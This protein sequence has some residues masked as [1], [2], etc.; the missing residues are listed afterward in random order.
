[1][2]SAYPFT[3]GA[4]D[5]AWMKQ[6]ETGTGNVIV[7]ASGVVIDRKVI[8]T[9]A[10]NIVGNRHAIHFVGSGQILIVMAD[11]RS[12]FTVDGAAI[13]WYRD[14]N[15]SPGSLDCFLALNGNFSFKNNTVASHVVAD[16]PTD[17]LW[18]DKG[19]KNWFMRLGS[20]TTNVTSLVVQNNTFTNENQ[21]AAGLLMMSG[22]TYVGNIRIEDNS[23]SNFHGAIYVSHALGASIDDN[24]LF[25]NSLGNIVVTDA[26]TSQIS[27]NMIELPGNGTTGDGMT[28]G[29][30]DQDVVRNN[31][32]ING[33]CYGIWVMQGSSRTTF[34]RNTIH[35]GITDAV[36]IAGSGVFSDIRIIENTLTDQHGNAV[37][38]T[39]V[40][41]LT[42]VDNVIGGNHSWATGR[43]HLFVNVTGLS[44][45][46]NVWI[47]TNVSTADAGAT[48]GTNLYQYSFGD[49]PVAQ[50]SASST[51]AEA[52]ATR[53]ALPTTSAA[54][55]KAWVDSL[56]SGTGSIT[57]PT[58]GVTIDRVVVLN[59]P[60]QIIGNGATLRFAG[61]GSIVVAMSNPN[62]EFALSG[63]NVYWDRKIT[64]DA[65]QLI[66][67]QKGNL[68]VTGDN[69]YAESAPGVGNLPWIF[70]FTLGPT[71][72][73]SITI[74][75][76]TFMSRYWCSVGLLTSGDPKALSTLT[77]TDNTVKSMHG[78][79][80]LDGARSIQ[81]LRNNFSRN[82]QNSIDLTNVNGGRIAN[83]RILF[84]GNGAAG[85]AIAV[86]QSKFLTIERNDVFEAQR[87][88]LT[89]Q[90][91]VQTTVADNF[92]SRSHTGGLQIIGARTLAATG[93]IVD[94]NVFVKNVG[95]GFAAQ[96]APQIVMRDN[97]FQ[98]NGTVFSSNK[99]YFFDVVQSTIVTGNL[100]DFA[101]TDDDVTHP[102]T[103]GTN[104]QAYDM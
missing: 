66:L 81:I 22:R 5:R 86:A 104:V 15:V 35:G 10:E 1:M 43:Q 60:R 7:P 55:N 97:L 88:G 83:N 3:A 71:S 12:T 57:V 100:R 51:V 94:G 45:S 17:P 29:G 92:I 28:L 74:A 82:S 98:D 23:I 68:R 37:S 75:S 67:L 53:P 70:N 32:I 65:S 26:K 48:M 42:L 40:N 41:G 62:S 47:P 52:A 9:Q 21:Y 76:S 33:S 63:T 102:K 30:L 96:S 24:R 50:V 39:N 11:P 99:Q 59:N 91:T 2:L 101:Y 13:D 79:L 80:R 90:N 72:P 61:Q 103:R 8:V 93:L 44:A 73:S 77:F 64:T 18:Y 27:N 49:W 54:A 16:S 84:A 69:F 25:R 87:N 95:Y 14:P 20:S 38:A 85:G 58:T 89:L 19:A 6:L 4:V 78:G 46:G 56:A 36:C 31:T 34:Y